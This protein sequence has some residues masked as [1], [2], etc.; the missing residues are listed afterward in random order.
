MAKMGRP[1][2]D[3][4]KLKM[5]GVRLTDEEHDKLKNYAANH[6]QTITQTLLEGI[7]NLYEKENNAAE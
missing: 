3:T 5:V 4:P 7:E 2:I 1:K 6:N